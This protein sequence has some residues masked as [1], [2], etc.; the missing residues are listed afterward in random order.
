M[1]TKNFVCY[2]KKK[3]PKKTNKT[4]FKDNK[5]TSHPVLRGSY[6]NLKAL[7]KEIPKPF[8]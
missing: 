1:N 4:K 7:K 5:K 6:I 8:W 2:F 3:H